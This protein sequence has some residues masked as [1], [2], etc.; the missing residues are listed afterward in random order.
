MKV[1]YNKLWK[2]LIDRGMKKD[3][4]R[5]AVGMSP[6]TLAKMGKNENV[7]MDVLLRICNELKCD[8][9]DIMEAI[10]GDNK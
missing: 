7:S 10:P 9:G 2:I 4:L 3:E 8:L 1:S 5:L 6:N